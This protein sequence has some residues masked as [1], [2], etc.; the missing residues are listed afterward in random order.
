LRFVPGHDAGPGKKLR[1]QVWDVRGDRR[2]ALAQKPGYRVLLGPLPEGRGCELR[3]GLALHPPAWVRSPGVRFRAS[4]RNGAEQ[5]V[6]LEEE[7]RASQGVEPRWLDRVSV[8]PRLG[9]GESSLAFETEP[10]GGAATPYDVGGWGA[11]H[12]VCRDAPAAPGPPLERPSIVLVSIDT[13][14]ADHL[15][16]YGYRR[17]TSPTLDR[18]AAESIVFDRAFATAPWTLPSHASLLTGLYPEEHGAG[19]VEPTDPLPAGVPTLAE[20]LRDAGY[21]TLA[22]TAGGVVS[23]RSGLDRGFEVWRE[24][25][26]ANLRSVLPSVFDELGTNAERPFFL[27][28]HTYDVHG[29]Y[30]QPPDAFAFR[31]D[32]GDPRVSPSE[33]ERIVRMAHHRYQRFERFR[34]LEEVVAAYDSGIRFVD[35]ALAVLFARLRETGVW[36]GALVIVTSDHG[37]SLYER[38]LYVGHTYTLHDEVVRVPLLVRLPEARRAGRSRELVDLV[39]LAPLVLDEA[40]LAPSVRFSGTNPLPR[41]EGSAPPRTLVRGEASHTGQG[42]ARSEHWKLV[43]G[44]GARTDAAR[45]PASLRDRFEGGEAWFDLVTDPGERR[46]LVWRGELEAGELVRLRTELESVPRLAARSVTPPLDAED[47]AH[48]RELGYIE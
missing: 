30:E 28:L 25:T 42:Y 13:L 36:E 1:V 41:D 44:T 16:L 26:R 15:G 37:E 20:T 32:A 35:D 29:P 39:D 31:A 21:R 38:A 4:L 12:L 10:M 9:P 18:L 3:V 34:G 2:P 33:W 7:V 48:L 45:F 17:R 40:G 14:R 47:A 43:S 11:P 19:R 5:R 6:L 27:F 8:V 24:H 46:N 22:F 23:R